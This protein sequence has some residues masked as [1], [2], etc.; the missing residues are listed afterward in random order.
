MP[1]YRVQV[2]DQASQSPWTMPA[3]AVGGA[4]LALTAAANQLAA[5]RAERRQPPIG[6]F[7]NADGVRL[8]YIDKGNGPPVVLIHGTGAM[9]Q[10]FSLSILHGLTR[11]HR[12]IVFDRPGYGY[13]ERPRGRRW[14][15]EAQ[16]HVIRAGLRQLGLERPLIV[17]HSYGA[18]VALSYGALFPAEIRGIVLMAGYYFPTFRPAIPLFGAL[19]TPVL[20]DLFRY[21]VAPVLFRAATPAILGKTFAP[22]P[23]P[24]V[25]IENFPFDLAYRPSQ[26]RAAADDVAGLRPWARR[27]RHIYPAIRPAT[28]ILSGMVD[29][30]V[31]PNRHS[32]RLHR[33][34]PGSILRLIPGVG[35][36]L[37]H[38]RPDLVLEAVSNF[39]PTKGKAPEAPALVP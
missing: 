8:H 32:T 22:N 2:R 21:T 20:G 4:V 12:V 30:I 23:A 7:L 11:R 29:Q 14:T 10:D 13:S 26:I 38:V 34:I 36:M 15:P 17:G 9:I 35:H 37:H 3:F 39:D 33:L 27:M 28:V 24:S 18:S 16:A 1:R 31:D 5:W 6:G 25:F 19:A